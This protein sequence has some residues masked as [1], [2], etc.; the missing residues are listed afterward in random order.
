MIL[1]K[2]R[3]SETSASGQESARTFY[4]WSDI[5]CSRSV[6]G[7][8]VQMVVVMTINLSCRCVKVTTRVCKR[9]G[10]TASLQLHLQNHTESNTWNHCMLPNN[11]G[12]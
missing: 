11:L 12:S 7:T 4:K 9:R 2:R 8:V 1:D 5:E 10:M 6:L 3:L